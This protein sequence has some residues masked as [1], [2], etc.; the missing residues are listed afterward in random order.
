MGDVV[1]NKYKLI[2][3]RD[4]YSTNIKKF[5][6]L[7]LNNPRFRVGNLILSDEK[8]C[9][10]R[11]NNYNVEKIIKINDFIITFFQIK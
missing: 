3:D 2:N 11:F 7:C 6:H 10:T 5:A 8:E 4:I 1:N 9:N